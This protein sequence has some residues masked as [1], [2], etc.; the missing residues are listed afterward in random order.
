VSR[1]FAFLMTLI[2]M[3]GLGCNLLSC[4]WLP[5]G[6]PAPGETPSPPEPSEPPP[7]V[8]PLPTA[9]PLISTAPPLIPT[10]PLCSDPQPPFVTD[11]EVLQT[12]SLPEPTARSPYRDPV[13]GTC[14]VRVTDRTTDLSSDDPSPGLKNEY[15]RVQSFNADGS[16]VLVRGIE[17]TWYLYDAHTLQPLG[18]LPLEVEPRWDAANP[19][20]VYFSDETRLMAY[21]VGTGEETLVHEFA[22]DFPGQSLAAVWTKYEGR[23]SADTR[24][25][26]LMAEDEEWQAVAFLVYDRQTD[27]VVASLDMRG[28]PGVEEDIDHVTISPLGNY[29]LASF[30]HYCEPGQLGD[31]AH[32]CG[33][34]VYDRDLTNGR[35]LLRTIGH[36]DPALDAEGREVIIFQDIDQDNISMLDLASGTVTPLWPIDFSHTGI[37]L[38][39]SGCSFRRPGWALVSTYDGDPSAYTWMDDQVFAVE[40][41]PGG[42]VVRLAHSHSLVDEDQEH[43]YWAEPHASVNQDF[44]RV[45]FTTNWGRS[46]TGEVEMFLIELPADWSERLP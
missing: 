24:Y 14:L 34:M 13:F 7:A 35:S 39:F 43:D 25:W 5:S 9:P 11:L 29:F 46:G 18:E 16:R 20:L 3:T 22:N 21:D 44:T 4:P 28:V 2:V 40:L 30:D 1:R 38:H 33:L 12:P 42:R 27:Q 23:P 26:G 32:P 6:V 41:K 8:S 10:A 45:L 36:Y 37:G 15:S 31:D 17:G 19:N